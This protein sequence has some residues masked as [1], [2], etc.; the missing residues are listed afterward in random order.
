M[1]DSRPQ[2]ESL[3]AAALVA[4]DVATIVDDE[5]RALLDYL[6]LPP[7]G[8][9]ADTDGPPNRD[10]DAS[11]EVSGPVRQALGERRQQ[12]GGQ[13]SDLGQ[14]LDIPGF[15]PGELAG[16]RAR[17]DDL[18]R[19]GNHLEP[20]W[21]GPE[22]RRAF[23]D[24][25][26]SAQSHIH[27]QTYIVGG[28]VG[29]QMAEVL[30]RKVAQGVSVRVM[31]TASGFVISGGPS[32]TGF[33]SRLSAMRSHLYND[34]YVRKRILERLR[35][36]GVAV[37][38]SAPIGRH[39][40]RRAMREQ[41]VKNARSYRRWARDR[42]LPDAWLA[43][44][45]A[46]DRVCSPGFA[47]VDH[48]K[49]LV[50]DGWRALIGSQ[51]IA[52]SY[53]YDNELDEDPRVNRRRWQWHDSSSVLTGPCVARLN[54]LFA[55]RWALSGGDFFDCDDPVYS[56]PPRRAGTAAVT[57]EASIPG[58]LQ[59]P[60]RRNFW[61]LLAS[62]AGADRRPVAVGS[63]PI[64]NRIMQLPALTREELYV[65]H[66]Y[67]SDGELLGHWAKAASELPDFTLVV[68]KHYD[69]KLL[70]LE[71]DRFYAE[72]L[73]GGA[74][75]QGYQRAIMHSKIA[76]A[77]R[78]YVSTGSYNLTLRSARADLELQFFVQCQDYGRTVHQRIREDLDECQP[79]R[80]GAV[81]RF[82]ARR[83]IP[84]FDAVIRYFFL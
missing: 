57:L 71:C 4:S 68:P 50:V 72:M 48:R 9:L 62:L 37:L 56:P 34:M 17:L 13:F 52:D 55:S 27:L 39:W 31:F 75:V 6:N 2:P 12:A 46:I 44:Q 10:S 1:S 49:I 67:P 58:T 64:R 30:A 15:G 66:C 70:G 25:L 7:V 69:T 51:N 3:G 22:A 74:N 82:R 81:D 54:R 24:L 77:D 79:I 36:G 40:K 47:F 20:V 38:D 26:E 29:L 8:C 16:I 21:G 43:E 59:V 41:G 42:G 61:R 5:A 32:G 76:V 35:T 60:L 11:Y 45:E 65:E 80:P 23:F 14:L 78:Y 53:L 84:I 19:Y 28:E 83:S 18:A 73:A 63:H 33:V